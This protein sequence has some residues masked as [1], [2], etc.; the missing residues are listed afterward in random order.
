MS[1][2]FFQPDFV[3]IAYYHPCSKDTNEFTV[4]ELYQAFKKRLLAELTEAQTRREDAA[5]KR[6]ERLE[7][8]WYREQGD[9]P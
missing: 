9:Q 5:Q 7:E 8:E 6:L 4:E 3:L 2:P 1:S